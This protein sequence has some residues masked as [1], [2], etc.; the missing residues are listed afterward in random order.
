MAQ[1]TPKKYDS[2]ALTQQALAQYELDLMVG[3]QRER[4]RKDARVRLA[5]WLLALAVAVAAAAAW[6]W[7][8]G[9]GWASQSAE[10]AGALFLAHLYLR[11]TAW[12]AP[13][14]IMPSQ[15]APASR[16]EARGGG[17]F[18]TAA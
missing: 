9:S 5:N 15:E 7:R 8:S 11:I 16:Q 3:Q 17:S 18:H 14:A 12:M 2:R 13:P 6:L 4:R 10:L 1:A